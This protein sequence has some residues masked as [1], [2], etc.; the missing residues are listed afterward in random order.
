MEAYAI[1]QKFLWALHSVL[2]KP[3]T[4]CFPTPEP[5]RVYLLFSYRSEL[6]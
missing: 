5:N 4:K 2:A 6:F 3:S 1:F